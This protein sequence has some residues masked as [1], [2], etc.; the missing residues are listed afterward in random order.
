[1]TDLL[2]NLFGNLFGGQDLLS[3]TSH[4]LLTIVKVSTCFK[5]VFT[6][7]IGLIITNQKGIFIESCTFENNSSDYHKVTTTIL[8]K[9]ICKENPKT[10]FQGDFKSFKKD[11]FE[12]ELKSRMM[13]LADSSFSHFG[14]I[15]LETQ[16]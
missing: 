5:L 12:E 13:S 3:Y 4:S 11:R 1:M 9:T 2:G 8:R 6:I 10:K 14:N 15:S 7:C 16:S